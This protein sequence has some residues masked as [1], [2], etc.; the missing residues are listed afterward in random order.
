[1]A[2]PPVD[3]MANDAIIR[4][5][6]KLAGVSTSAVRIVSGFTGSIKIVE[7]EGVDPASLESVILGLD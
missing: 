3:G 2:A 1:M 6:A 5:L 7:L 4:Y